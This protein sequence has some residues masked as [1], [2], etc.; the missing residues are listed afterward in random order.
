MGEFDT[1]YKFFYRPI[2][3]FG[4]GVGINESMEKYNLEKMNRDNQE[5]LRMDNISMSDDE[6][7]NFLQ[8]FLIAKGYNKLIPKSLQDKYQREADIEKYLKN[9]DK[10]RQRGILS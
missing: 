9:M 1:D 8:D 7:L 4:S 6:S 5:Q 2:L 10:L 3:D